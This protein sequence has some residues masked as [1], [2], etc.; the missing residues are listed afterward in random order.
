MSKLITFALCLLLPASVYAQRSEGVDS[1]LL[2]KPLNVA[3]SLNHDSFQTLSVSLCDASVVERDTV[4]ANAEADLLL[5]SEIRGYIEKPNHYFEAPTPRVDAELDLLMMTQG[6]RRYDMDSIVNRRY[7]AIQYGI[8]ESQS[9]SGKVSRTFNKNPKG[10]KLLLLSPMIGL[11]EEFDLGENSRFRITNLDFIDGTPFTVQATTKNGKTSFVQMKVDEE[12]FPDIHTKRRVAATKTTSSPTIEFYN[13]S[14][15]HDEIKEKY[16]ELQ[17]D[18]V[19]V[20]G[21]PRTWYNPL[22]MKPTRM[23]K[24]GDYFLD[25]ANYAGN[26]VQRLGL[27]LKGEVF[28]RYRPD[29]WGKLVFTPTNGV[30]ID[31]FRASQKEFMELLPENI[32]RV[33]FYGEGLNIERD[34]YWKDY[35]FVT[36]KQLARINNKT[37]SMMSVTPLGYKQSCEFYHPQYEARILTVPD[38]RTT[39]YWNPNLQASPNGKWSFDCLIPSL[40]KKVLLTVEGVGEDGKIVSKT[41]TITIQ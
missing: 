6:W 7:P 1:M 21:H 16:R 24:E 28:G 12:V 11:K 23:L 36:T 18:E 27:T 37:L 25:H 26:I 31:G 8:E 22:G 5:C 10:M 9:I 29:K 3:F 34:S 4:N 2:R 39:Y 17:L 20:V 19:V 30:Y 15:L 35:L 32:S 13:K 14:K 41:K 33:E 40:T 38:Y